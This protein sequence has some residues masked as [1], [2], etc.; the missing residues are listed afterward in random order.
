MDEMGTANQDN[1]AHEGT[2]DYSSSTCCNAITPCSLVV[3]FLNPQVPKIILY[4]V[5]KRVIGSEP[6]VQFIYIKNLS[7]PP[8]A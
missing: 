6:T 7:P 4:G 5:S 2:D 1:N 3:D 8:K